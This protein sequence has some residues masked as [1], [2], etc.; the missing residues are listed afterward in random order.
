MKLNASQLD[1]NDIAEYGLSEG[2]G[3]PE[4]MRRKIRLVMRADAVHKVILNVPL[5]EKL[6]STYGDDKGSPPTTN[7]FK[8]V[9]IEN[10]KEALLLIKVTKK[11]F[12]S[13]N[14]CHAN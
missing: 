6:S 5:L 13:I 3:I 2:K 10:G 12:V 9:G 11:K 14:G 8:L 1:L 4:R 7:N